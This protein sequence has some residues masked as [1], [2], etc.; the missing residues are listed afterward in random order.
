M[1]WTGEITSV[2][3][4]RRQLQALFA[5]TYLSVATLLAAAG[6]LIVAGDSQV[7]LW[8]LGSFALPGA[9]IRIYGGVMSG[10]AILL[11]WR[12]LV[13]WRRKRVV[14]P[15]AVRWCTAPFVLHIA[16]TVA[17]SVFADGNVGSWLAATIYLV[18]YVLLNAFA[19]LNPLVSKLMK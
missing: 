15:R 7:A 8:L 9:A 14:S 10:G 3:K 18:A 4:Q 12:T 17:Y 6:M 11:L 19:M 5:L 16:G 1:I 2:S 13:S